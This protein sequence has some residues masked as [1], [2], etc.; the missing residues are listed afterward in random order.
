MNNNKF[1]LECITCGVTE[2]INN[3]ASTPLIIRFEGGSPIIPYRMFIY[4]DRCGNSMVMGITMPVRIHK[5][6][7][8]SDDEIFTEELEEI[9]NDR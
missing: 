2:D 4:C 7:E 8:K 5:L 3:L 9:I 6:T 1:D